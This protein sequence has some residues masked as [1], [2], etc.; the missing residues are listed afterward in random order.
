MSDILEPNAGQTQ[1]PEDTG[2][3]FAPRWSGCNGEFGDSEGLNSRQNEEQHYRKHAVVG[4]EWE[5]TLS[6][7]DYRTRATEHLNS[8][9]AERVIELCQAEDLAVVKY[10][11]ESGD[12][13]IARSD[14]GTIKTFFRPKDIDYVL[15]KIKTGSWDDPGIVDGFE[16][17][18][19]AIAVSDDPE[20]AYLFAR[21]ETLAV[22]LPPQAHHVVLGFSDN[23]VRPD[24]LLDMLA[25]LGEYRFCVFELQRRVLTEAQSDT[26]FHFQKKIAGSSASF[27][28]LE[29]YRS[30]EL[31]DGLVAGLARKIAMVQTLWNES[32]ALIGNVEELC[33][34]LDERQLIGYAI[35]ELRV[36][37]LHRRLVE[38][39]VSGFGS[40][41][42]RTDIYLRSV[43][44]QL[45]V[46]LS[47]KEE[48]R[49]VPEGFFWRQIAR[50]IG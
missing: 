39:D 30:R 33:N 20:I 15:R 27:E 25:R 1:D 22:E 47:Y 32:A 7:T 36:L 3:R 43:L 48:H 24:E 9:D 17:A 37:H 45:T 29:R 28:A 49:V 11:L 38:L 12:L 13:G 16:V 35:L 19:E 23:E 50:N 40:R 10:D 26:M 14:A 21:L 31:V 2:T 4:Q 5:Q 6:L 44:Y 8:L 46:K 41:L 42:L 18:A 34:A